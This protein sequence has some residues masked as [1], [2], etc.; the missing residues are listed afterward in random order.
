MSE[1]TDILDA[2]RSGE[3]ESQ[4]QLLV[5][6]YHE[7][8]RL[9]ARQLAAEPSGQTLQPTAL[10]HEAWLRLLDGGEPR[11]W[12]SRGHFFAA[13]ARS[14]RRILVDNARHKQTERRGGS[15]KRMDVA[16]DAVAEAESSDDLLV[17]DEALQRLGER[18]PRKARLVELRYF[19]GLTME[20]AADA[21][22][23]SVAT[24]ERDW[25][26]ARAWLRR[27]ITGDG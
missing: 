26:F 19:A 1:V 16:L 12:D 8:R 9:A 22:D 24:A 7:L 17:I 27:E 2:V 6:V 13:A 20:Q 23:I 3:P 15:R 18:D 5:A 21:L 11:H 10:V 14:M 4:E 25:R